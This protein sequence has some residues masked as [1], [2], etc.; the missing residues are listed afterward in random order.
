[1]P[2]LPAARPPPILLAASTLPA[3]RGQSGTAGSDARDDMSVALGYAA[4]EEDAEP[5]AAEVL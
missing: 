2:A 1:M 3:L 4:G 5:V